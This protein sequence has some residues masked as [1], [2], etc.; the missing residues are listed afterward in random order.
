MFQKKKNGKTN[1]AIARA[2]KGAN[3]TIYTPPWLARKMVEIAI[4]KSLWYDKILDPCCGENRIFWKT[5]RKD[6]IGLKDSKII[7]LDIINGLDFYD[8]PIENKFDIILMNPLFTRDGKRLNISN[9]LARGFE[10]LEKFG[11]IVS[12]LPACFIVNSENRKHWLDMHLIDYKWLP[13]MTF[14]RPLHTA[15]GIFK[16][17][18]PQSSWFIY[19]P[20]N[21]KR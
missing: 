6:F 21:Y 4:E 14:G 13:K 1:P 9:F 5:I 16:Q 2:A 3:N 17:N 18:K 12:I 15:L 8:Y 7:E 20:D 10:H 11:V 19:E